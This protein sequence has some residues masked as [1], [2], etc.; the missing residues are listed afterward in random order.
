MFALQ[1]QPQNRDDRP[2]RRRKWTTSTTRRFSPFLAGTLLLTASCGESPSPEEKASAEVGLNI[3]AGEGRDRLCLRAEQ[4]REAA[5]VTYAGEG[6]T[7]CTVRGT[8][9]RQANAIVPNGDATCR[10]PVTVT[11][12]AVQLGAASAACAYYCGPKASFAGKRF[13]LTT[14]GG[15]AVDLAG[16]PLC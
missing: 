9:D 11:A 8:F 6:D 5:F 3:Y 2:T 15:E 12:D 1:M 4:D 14:A 16:D 7:S 10:I 13:A